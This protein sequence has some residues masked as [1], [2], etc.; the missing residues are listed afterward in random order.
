MYE[1]KELIKNLLFSSTNNAAIRNVKPPIVNDIVQL[2]TIDNLD[3]P[4]MMDELNTTL[5]YLTW[6]K[7]WSWRKTP[8]NTCVRW[9]LLKISLL[10]LFNGFWD[11]EVIPGDLIDA[12][13]TVLF[14]KGDRSLCNNYRGISLFSIV[15]KVFADTIGSLRSTTRLK[16]RRHKICILN[17]Q[18]QKFCTPFTCFF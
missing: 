11:T 12:D 1:Q 4:I 2:P 5:R 6:K 3:G 16:R 17:W 15:G 14:K 8:G 7:P 13:I 10:L 18:K 9:W